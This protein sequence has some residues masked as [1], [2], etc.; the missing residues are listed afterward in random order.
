VTGLPAG[1]RDR[2]AGVRLL[3]LDVDGVLTDGTLYYGAD[4]EVLKAFHV[5]DGFGLK[6]LREEGIAAA[7]ISGRRAPALERR[8]SELGL[9]HA[10]L[11]RDDKARA[12]DE[13]L[14]EVGV[15][16]GAVAYVGDDVLDLPVLRRAGLSIAP[17]DAHP[18][19]REEVAWV[20]SAGGGRAVVRE[21]AD[22]LLDARGRFRDAYEEAV[23]RRDGG[24]G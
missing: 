21:I 11:G 13:L 17:A 22:G 18:L 8:L 19:V 6:V 14:A 15:P 12:F 3:V 24:G 23:A 7:V 9:E 4:G 10:F 5:R 1:A 2:A 16:D 20:T